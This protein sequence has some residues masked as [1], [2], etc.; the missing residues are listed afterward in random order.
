MAGRCFNF[1]LDVHP[2]ALLGDLRRRQAD[3]TT[4]MNC[5]LK[6]MHTITYS[7]HNKLVDEGA[8]ATST[9][10]P[11]AREEETKTKLEDC[12]SDQGCTAL[13]KGGCFSKRPP[14]P[15]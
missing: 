7:V 14:M 13:G 8:T 2:E 11:S 1:F 10:H 5:S 12:R 9:S 3:G 4:H 6:T 15:G